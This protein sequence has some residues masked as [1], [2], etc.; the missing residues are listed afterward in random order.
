MNGIQHYTKGENILKVIG[1]SVA[2]AGSKGTIS[3]GEKVALAYLVQLAELHFTAA[4][5]YATLD[6]S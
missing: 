2:E 5:T 4:R 6:G 1:D 3:D